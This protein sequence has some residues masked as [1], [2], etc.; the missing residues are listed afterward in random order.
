MVF[1]GQF[2]R[3]LDLKTLASHKAECDK[4]KCKQT[5]EISFVRGIIHSLRKK[6]YEANIYLPILYRVEMEQD[7][8]LKGIYING[9][10]YNAIHIQVTDIS[11]PKSLFFATMC[12]IFAT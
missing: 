2:A 3:V 4:A 9:P 10:F 12:V 6:C 8:C 1:N 5:Y 11:P 7:L